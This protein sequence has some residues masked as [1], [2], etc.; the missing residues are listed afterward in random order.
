MNNNSLV[1]LLDTNVCIM[2]LKGRSL[3]INHHLDNLAND[4]MWFLE[5]GIKNLKLPDLSP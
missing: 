5:L 4:C 2:Y 3:S 1:Y